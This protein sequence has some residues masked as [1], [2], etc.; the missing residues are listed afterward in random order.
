M[1]S[2]L[3]NQ[4]DST[5]KG[6]GFEAVLER[7]VVQPRRESKLGRGVRSTE[8]WYLSYGMKDLG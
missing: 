7:R 1:F 2:D 8:N 3:L 6:M 4:K 5:G